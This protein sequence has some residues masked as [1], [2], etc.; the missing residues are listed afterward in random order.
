M[1]CAMIRYPV[2]MMA[3]LVLAFPVAASSAAA[4]MA[5]PGRQEARS[6]SRIL[7]QKLR[8]NISLN[9]LIV[10]SGYSISD[11]AVAGFLA[12]FMD[13]NPS[14]KSISTLKKDTLVR[15]PLRYLKK[16]SE[17]KSAVTDK[18]PVVKKRFVRRQPKIQID[19]PQVTVSKAV[20]LSSI[21]E[22]LAALG[23]KVT[24]DQEGFKFFQISEKSNLSFD[25]ALFP[26]IDLHKERLL[27]VDYTG[28]FS[29]DMKNLLEVAWPEYRVVIPSRSS[30]LRALVPAVLRESGYV[31]Q[32]DARMIS[33]GNAQIEY[34]SDFLV[35]GTTD[36][37]MQGD[38]SL[39]SILGK[40][41]FQTPPALASWFNTRNISLIELSEYQKT[42][43][44]GKNAEIYPVNS[45][46]T[47]REF[48]ETCIKIMGYPFERD[49]EIS[50]SKGKGIRYALMADIA[51]DL[52]YRKKII[53]F[54]DISDMELHAAGQFGA[55]AARVEPQEKRTDVLRKILSLL[56]VD[57]KNQQN[58]NSVHLTP[59]GMR[60]RLI[61]PGYLVHAL[62]GTFFM[63]DAEFDSDILRKIV[64]DDITVV[65]F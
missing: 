13:L 44:A 1:E 35:Y 30:D 28:S 34:R 38:I 56:S 6:G 18:A 60:Y 21:K 11:E 5:A 43:S 50:L 58:S 57:F 16:A 10:A 25:S 29:A 37:R 46:A 49:A 65:Q 42:A 17:G 9:D 23:E 55:D 48:A 51:I 53:E 22:L 14:V 27:V 33:G 32:E 45:A 62:K 59:K 3:V 20:I 40:D 41:E 24:V 7:T 15:I 63:T 31:F 52:G 47:H 64:S 12:D 4:E 39:I 19:K 2:C 26:V 54:S 8:N 61:M 36:D